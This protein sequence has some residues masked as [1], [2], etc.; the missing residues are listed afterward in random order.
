MKDDWSF[1]TN[2]IITKRIYH[3][4]EINILRKKLIEDIEKAVTPKVVGLEKVDNQIDIYEMGREYLKE[5]VKI[6]INKRFGVDE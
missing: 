6:I 2:K 3:E 5:Q 4:Y 1:N